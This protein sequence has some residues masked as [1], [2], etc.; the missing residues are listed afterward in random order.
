[1]FIQQSLYFCKEALRTYAGDK[2]CWRLRLKMKIEPPVMKCFYKWSISN[3]DIVIVQSEIMKRYIQMQL[4]VSES[5]IHVIPPAIPESIDRKSPATRADLN[6]SDKVRHWLYVGN[7]C[8]YKKVDT[9]IKAAEASKERGL[10]WL[11]HIVGFDD[12]HTN[13]D[14]PIVFHNYM[15]H[16]KLADLYLLADA[17]ILPSLTET[18]GLP[19]LEALYCGTPVVLADRP[20]AREICEKQAIYFDPYSFQS[21]IQSLASVPPKTDE[22]CCSLRN[23]VSRQYNQG[24]NAQRTWQI[25]SKELEQYM[26]KNSGE[27]NVL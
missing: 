26:P 5:K 12:K 25:L 24:A 20:Y 21:L 23:W 16:E 17:L 27:N 13:N 4:G 8:P 11:F 6:W 2:I 22:S 7:N 19:I 14:L 3:S 10:P 15:G 1:L 18:V 9:I